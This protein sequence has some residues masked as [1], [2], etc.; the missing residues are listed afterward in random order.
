MIRID[1]A[2][3]SRRTVPVFVFASTRSLSTFRICLSSGLDTSGAS[4]SMVLVAFG[5]GV[6]NCSMQ[7]WK[8]QIPTRP[9]GICESENPHW[10]DVHTS[11]WRHES[12]KMRVVSM[13]TKRWIRL[14]NFGI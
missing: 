4:D 1:E 6:Y 8:M 14:S 2:V 7:C 3:L 10:F 13:R 11:S 12:V 5:G 9:L